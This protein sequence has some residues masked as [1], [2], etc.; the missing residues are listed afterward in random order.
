MCLESR[1]SKICLVW[2]PTARSVTKSRL[3]MARFESPPRAEQGPPRS[4]SVGRERWA[5][6]M[7]GV[8]P[9]AA[10]ART[11]QCPHR[12]GG[13]VSRQGL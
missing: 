2:A 11:Q 5:V 4:R 8:S 12:L 9:P 3:A 13:E 1:L 10:S 7:A 6:I